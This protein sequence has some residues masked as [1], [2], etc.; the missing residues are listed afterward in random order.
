MAGG[1]D[2]EF[3]KM[4][5]RNRW[6]YLHNIC[7]R[8]ATWSH[9]DAHVTNKK[10]SCRRDRATLCVI[11]YFAKSPKVTRCHSKWHCWV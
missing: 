2:F 5:I 3:H 8:D 4:L 9:G 1:G 6:R 10:L 11:E 7:N